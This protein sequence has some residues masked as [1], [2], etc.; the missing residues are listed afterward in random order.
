MSIT[1]AIHD[2]IR[3]EFHCAILGVTKDSEDWKRP[4]DGTVTKNL[5]DNLPDGSVILCHE[6]SDQTASELPVAIAELIK[7][8]YRSVTVSQLLDS[9]I[10]K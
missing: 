6:W 7:R 8:G 9:R 10:K 1:P 3:N 2:R 4:P 5:L